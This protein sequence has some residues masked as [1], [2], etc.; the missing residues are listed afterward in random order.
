MTASSVGNS[1]PADPES[2]G[3]ENASEEASER[4]RWAKTVRLVGQI[5][6]VVATLSTALTVT[7]LLLPNLTP[8]ARPAPTP[9]PPPPAMAGTIE[10]VEMSADPPR[11]I[12]TVRIQG[13]HGKACQL[14]YSI[15]YVSTHDEVPGFESIPDSQWEPD[16]QDDKATRTF[17]I[18]IPEQPG[19]Y[20]ARV[21]LFDPK[22]TELDTAIGSNFWV[23]PE[24]SFH[25]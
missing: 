22:G 8:K 6:I 9:T 24:G 13:F 18:A 7:F 1:N 19:E 16:S 20:M 15:N 12:V 10:S 23:Y 4:S 3:D 21:R 17:Q 14:Y 11:L 25:P 2:P 5:G